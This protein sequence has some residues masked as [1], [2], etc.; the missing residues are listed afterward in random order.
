MV[1][2]LNKTCTLNM[3]QM[4]VNHSDPEISDRASAAL[5]KAFEAAKQ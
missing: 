2:L 4:L 5:E 1:M 3:A